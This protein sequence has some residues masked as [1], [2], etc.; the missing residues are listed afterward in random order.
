MM[1]CILEVVIERRANFEIDCP[2]MHDL[3]LPHFIVT[4]IDASPDHVGYE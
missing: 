1:Y 4:Q 2:K 3:T